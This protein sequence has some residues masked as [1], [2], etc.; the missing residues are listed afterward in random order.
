MEAIQV[1]VVAE[2]GYC[3]FDRCP[4]CL[5]PGPDSDEHVPHGAIG[6]QIRTWTCGR[7]NNMLGTRLEDELTKWC[8]GS[9]P[10]I[11]AKGPGV[12]G[13]RRIPSTHL[14]WT[15]Q[16][17]FILVM[18]NR[19]D[20]TVR[21]MLAG[22]QITLDIVPP[23]QNRYQLAASS[24]PISRLAAIYAVSPKEPWRMRSEAT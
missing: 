7:C 8:F 6:G 14:R 13:R 20:P 12:R 11:R 9:L 15:N 1:Q 3:A 22:G 18:D 19:T 10:N 5:M 4:I 17:Q 2:I 21:D 16:R 24:T 23:D